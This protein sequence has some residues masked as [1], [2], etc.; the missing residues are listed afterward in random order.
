MMTY[1]KDSAFLYPVEDFKVRLS[2]L[3][4]PV[5]LFYWCLCST[6]L[7]PKTETRAMGAF[8]G[9]VL[10]VSLF[11]FEDL[12]SNIFYFTKRCPI[13]FPFTLKMML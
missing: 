7:V 12:I 3:S 13:F 8:S 4:L 5:F 6:S 10:L 2:V 1:R 11:D 9:Q